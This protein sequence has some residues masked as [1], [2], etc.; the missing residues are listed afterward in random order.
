VSSQTEFATEIAGWREHLQA[1]LARGVVEM[2]ACRECRARAG[3]ECV[4][5][6]VHEFR[7]RAFD[8]RVAEIKSE[9]ERLEL[10]WA[11]RM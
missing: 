6:V 11:I 10:E 3:T 8:L 7:V 5:G 9:I 2:E 4:G 1:V